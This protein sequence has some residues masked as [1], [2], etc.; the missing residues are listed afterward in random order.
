MKNFKEN[1]HQA[2]K[3]REPV[4]T[5]VSIAAL[6]A[7]KEKPLTV[8]VGFDSPLFEKISAALRVADE[9]G[10]VRGGAPILLT[11]S[12]HE[13]SSPRFEEPIRSI[14]E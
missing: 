13:R 14:N 1:L 12:T 7:A 3:S 9:L 11:P 6:L 4:L 8:D 5:E 10:V 2:E